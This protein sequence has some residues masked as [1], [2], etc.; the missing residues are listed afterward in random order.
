MKNM[1]YA[2]KFGMHGF[3]HHWMKYVKE[4][5]KKVKMCKGWLIVIVIVKVLLKQAYSRL[6]NFNS[7][8]FTVYEY[9]SSSKAL[10]SQLLRGEGEISLLMPTLSLGKTGFS[11]SVQQN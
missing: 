4:Q 8:L 2:T 11:Y 10:K 6:F 5:R 9:T 7:V 3:G 1:Y